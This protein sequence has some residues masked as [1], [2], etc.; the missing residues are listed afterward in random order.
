MT[1]VQNSLPWFSRKEHTSVRRR[2]CGSWVS[3]EF[4]EDQAGNDDER[5][6]PAF[7]Q[8]PRAASQTRRPGTGLPAEMLAG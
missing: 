6:K 4:S 5:S 3:H 2:C 1:A 7:S 8:T